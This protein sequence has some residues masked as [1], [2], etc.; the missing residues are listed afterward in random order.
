MLKR[1]HNDHARIRI[2]PLNCRTLL[3]AERL[4]DLDAALTEKGI[5][6]CALQWTRRE[7]FMSTTTEHF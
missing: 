6:I 4:L 2:Q 5:S 7:G 1:A 3:A